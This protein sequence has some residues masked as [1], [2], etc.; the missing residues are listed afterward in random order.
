MA[1]IVK[2]FGIFVLGIVAVV[3]LYATGTVSDPLVA[4]QLALNPDKAITQAVEVL[5]DTPKPEIV[6]AVKNETDG[7]PQ[8]VHDAATIVKPAEPAE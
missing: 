5:T 6:E 3:L 8:A 1:E 4:A 2:K 7:D